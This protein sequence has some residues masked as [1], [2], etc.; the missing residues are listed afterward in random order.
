MIFDKEVLN[1]QAL[2]F[3]AVLTKILSQT[4][5]LQG[6]HKIYASKSYYYITVT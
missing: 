2:I 3:Y 5:F 6:M 4:M 1:T